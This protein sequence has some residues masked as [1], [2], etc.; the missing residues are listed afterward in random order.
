MARL[1]VYGRGGGNG[2][3]APT[4]SVDA[5]G[6]R[7]FYHTDARGYVTHL[8]GA[9]G[10]VVEQY[11]YEAFGTPRVLDAQGNS[12][13]NASAVGNRFLFGGQQWRAELGVYDLRARAYHPG[14]GRFLQPDPA[15]LGAGRNLYGYCA[16]DPVNRRDPSGLYFQS[17]FLLEYDSGGG[18]GS[19]GGGFG[20]D[21]GDPG[22]DGGVGPGDRPLTGSSIPGT[23]SISPV[24]IIPGPLFSPGP[25]DFV[26]Q[27]VGQ[28]SGG[29]SNNPAEQTGAYS[30]AYPDGGPTNPESG[31][32]SGFTVLGVSQG[33]STAQSEAN[34]TQ[35]PVLYDTNS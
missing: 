34:A 6:G 14:L 29:S 21:G 30:V 17:I 26:N 3:G 19:D 13:G 20:D 1:Y 15:G 28:D 24:T 25:S 8:I 10:I 9:T 27:S 2:M 33:P 35:N 16:N 11:H 31:A 12:L 5:G 23:A 18:L 22:G 7:L 32:Y 4:L